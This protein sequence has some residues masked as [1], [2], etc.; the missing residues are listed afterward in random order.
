VRAEGHL[1]SIALTGA[2][3]LVFTAYTTYK[4]IKTRKHLPTMRKYG[5]MIL[6]YVAATLIMLEP[7]RHVVMDHKDFFISHGWNVSYIAEYRAGCNSD[8]PKCFALGGWLFT[9]GTTYTGF[10]MLFASTLWLI[11]A[12]EKWNEFRY[13]W[14]EIRASKLGEKV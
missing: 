4:T 14:R 9:F 5:P 12:R 6:A 8:T 3:M 11:D 13:R 10:I 1:I 2:M 7:V